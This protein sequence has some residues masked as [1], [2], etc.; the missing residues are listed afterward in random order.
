MKSKLFLKMLLITTG[1]VSV[2]TVAGVYATWSYSNTAPTPTETTIAVQLQDFKWDGAEDLTTSTGED[3][4]TL[5][6]EIVD[7]DYGLNTPGSYLNQTI[8]DRS[9]GWIT[10]ETLG[11]MDFWEREEIKN[12]FDLETENLSFL[13]HFPDGYGTT[14]YLYTTS[15]ELG[16]DSANIEVGK[17]IY[18]IYRTTL[19]KNAETGDYEAVKSE[20]GY[21]ESAYYSN[22]ITGTWLQY[23]SFDPESWVAGKRGTGFDDAINSYLGQTNTMYA[24]TATEEV[25]YTFTNATAGTRTITLNTEDTKYKVRVYNASRQQVTATAGAQD[26]L[27]IS[28]SASR[29]TKYYF[30]IS[31]G[32][33]VSYTVN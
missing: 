5:I 1:V 20:L 10:S 16:S 17:I 31:G 11:S 30:V 27:T 19:E 29:N 8:Q 3:H 23:P 13:I 18:P 32:T 12:Y 24:Q 2:A 9:S 15:V 33:S 7:G 14:Y 22:P 4:Y 28:W 25:Y 21:A 26:S 6:S